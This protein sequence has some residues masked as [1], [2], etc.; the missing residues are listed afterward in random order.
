MLK[1]LKIYPY[2]AKNPLKISF[3]FFK[4]GYDDLL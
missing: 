3:K 2:L 1:S 4:I